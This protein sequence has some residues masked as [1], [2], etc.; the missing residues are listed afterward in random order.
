MGRNETVEIPWLTESFLMNAPPPVHFHENCPA[1]FEMT[2]GS[3]RLMK[4]PLSTRAS[5]PSDQKRD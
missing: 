4:F 1:R 5:S 3:L 2:D